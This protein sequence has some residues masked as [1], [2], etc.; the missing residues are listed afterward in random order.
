MIETYPKPPFLPRI[1]EDSQPFWEGCAQHRLMFQR[2]AH[3]GQPR[4]PASFLCPRCLSRQY[5]WEPSAGRGSIY[6]F[7]VFR[8]AFHPALAN[9]VP[10]VVASVDLEE[11]VRLLTNIVNYGTTQIKCGAEVMVDFI[12]AGDGVT[13]PVFHCLPPPTEA[14]ASQ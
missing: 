13:L 4:L 12:D 8:R 11:G 6:S 10:Y 9:R 7:V 2:C 1:T 5:A 14:T 3:C